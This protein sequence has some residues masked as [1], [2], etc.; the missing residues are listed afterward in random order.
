LQGWHSVLKPDKLQL[1]AAA[2][3]SKHSGENTMR[4]FYF[5]WFFIFES[6]DGGCCQKSKLLTTGPDSANQPW[7][8]C[9]PSTL[10]IAFTNP[11]VTS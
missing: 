11:P 6:C 9:A 2:A 8:C 5:L 3:S 7:V 1:P 4:A 10:N